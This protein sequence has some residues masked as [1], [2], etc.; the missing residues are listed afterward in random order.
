M[1]KQS[2][3]LLIVSIFLPAILFSSS[4]TAPQLNTQNYQAYRN[5]HYKPH[6]PI[7]GGSNYYLQV[8]SSAPEKK[9]TTPETLR[10]RN[11]R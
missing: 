11:K 7:H 9:S 2:T 4:S 6:T 3:L 1:Q 10:S 8:Y 5:F